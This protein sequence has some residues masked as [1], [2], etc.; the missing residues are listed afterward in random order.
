MRCE[1]AF[2]DL[3]GLRGV[4]PISADGKADPPQPAAE[5]RK[6]SRPRERPLD[7]GGRDDEA[8]PEH[9]E[10]SGIG[11][12]ISAGPGS[13]AGKGRSG[14]QRKDLFR[15]LGRSVLVFESQEVVLRISWYIRFDWT[16]E[17]ESVVSAAAAFPS[18]WQ[19]ADERRSLKR[20]AETF[21][22]LVRDRGVFGGIKV[23][24]GL[25][26]ES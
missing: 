2:P 5:R 23:M 18:A 26:F 10:V 20:I 1:K 24:V 8:E 19:E 12:D 9:E 15:Q 6:Q 7:A 11:L 3:M 22:R 4:A 16:G 25:L 13:L 14:L 17:A 21:D